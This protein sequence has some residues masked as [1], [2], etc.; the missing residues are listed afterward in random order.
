MS[1]NSENH[2]PWQRRKGERSK[3]FGL[4]VLYRDI[5]PARSLSK[6]IQILTEKYPDCKVSLTQLK[7]YS[8]N[9]DWVERS[10]QFDDWKDAKKIEDSLE[11]IKEMNDRQAK[12]FKEMQKE[13][14]ERMDKAVTPFEFNILTLAYKRGADGERLSRGEATSKV[15]QTGTTKHRHT[16]DNADDDLFQDLME[17]SK[18]VKPEDVSKKET[19]EDPEESPGDN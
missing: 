17:K 6:L 1:E 4:F 16:I 18:Q 9:N 2:E 13:A 14:L 19:T 8:K 3:A 15:E 7:Y 10:E 11:A 12:D 5:G